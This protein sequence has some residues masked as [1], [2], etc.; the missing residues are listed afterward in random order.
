VYRKFENLQKSTSSN[1]KFH[2]EIV[3]NLEEVIT[4]N[5]PVEYL[6]V[7]ALLQL[8]KA[9]EAGRVGATG[10]RNGTGNPRSLPAHFWHHLTFKNHSFGSRWEACAYFKTENFRGGFWS[11]LR[12]NAKGVFAV[13]PPSACPTH[14]RGHV[15][16]DGSGEVQSK[17]RPAPDSRIHKTISEV[18]DNAERVGLKAPNIREIVAPVQ[19]KLSAEG[20]T[21]TGRRIQQLAENDAYKSRRRKPGITIAS[22]KRRK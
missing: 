13:W 6:S 3:R 1:Y 14:N 17:L 7:E 21:A 16:S 8:L 15:E 4:W 18:Y 12:F 11:N 10:T 2:D 5:A 22:E 9:L 19:K 20:Y